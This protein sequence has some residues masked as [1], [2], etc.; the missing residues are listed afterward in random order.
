MKPLELKV[1]R[2]STNKALVIMS[3]TAEQLNCELI[4]PDLAWSFGPNPLGPCSG[5]G[6]C[7]NGTCLCDAGWTGRSDWMNAEGFDCQ[8][9]M[10]T[11][12]ALYGVL[13]LAQIIGYYFAIPYLKSR[14]VAF[15]QIRESHIRRGEHYTIFQNNG[16]L[17][18]AIWYAVGGPFLFL[19]CIIKWSMNDERVGVT[20]LLTMLFIIVKVLF[21]ICVVLM[22]PT[23]LRAVLHEFAR[24]SKYVS[25]NDYMTGFMFLG[26]FVSGLLAI[27]AIMKPFKQQNIYIGYLFLMLYVSTWI[28]G[29]ALFIKARVIHTLDRSQQIAALPKTKVMKAKLV[30]MQNSAI[31]QGALLALTFLIQIIWPFFWTKHDYYLPIS[32]LV[33]P[34]VGL[35]V[36]RTSIS[37]RENESIARTSS[38][39]STGAVV[40]HQ[41]A[42]KVSDSTHNALYTTDNFSV[43]DGRTHSSS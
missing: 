32:W 8:I 13:A 16:V 4:F 6:T 39:A 27:A 7:V 30:S 35:R 21:Y 31:R 9:H 18:M 38:A 28:S 23:L 24:G 42:N 33:M 11:V 17:A 40:V 12:K 41:N 22:Q 37:D 19:Y 34:I 2:V 29:Q 25:L 20:W 43:D 26:Q 14:Y 15:L 36:A 3:L 5:H 10:P 1:V